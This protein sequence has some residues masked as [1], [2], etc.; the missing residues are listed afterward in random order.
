MFHS[1]PLTSIAVLGL[2]GLGACD[3]PHERSGGDP[4]S[5]PETQEKAVAE[6]RA[7][8]LQEAVA[9]LNRELNKQAQDIAAEKKNL[10]TALNNER[11]LVRKRLIDLESVRNNAITNRD[12]IGAQASSRGTREPCPQG[13][14]RP[15]GQGGSREAI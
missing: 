5:K 1:L 8:N 6:R 15:L 13:T 4:A 2:L 3:K 10:E 7:A 12:E 11:A 14:L 9:D